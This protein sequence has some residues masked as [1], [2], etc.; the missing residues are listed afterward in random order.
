MPAWACQV[1][2]PRVQATIHAPDYT[3]NLVLVLLPVVLLLLVGVG[4][5]FVDAFTR[6]FSLLSRHD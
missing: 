2:R 4:L 6:R 3:H 5:F 1:C